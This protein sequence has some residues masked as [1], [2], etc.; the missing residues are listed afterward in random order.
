MKISTHLLVGGPTPAAQTRS[1][2]RPLTQSCF[3][4][5]SAACEFLMLFLESVGFL[6]KHR[7]RRPTYIP[8][9][10]LRQQSS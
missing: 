4:H 10:A 7:K 6:R 8:M 2:E 3:P 5:C 1:V 9:S